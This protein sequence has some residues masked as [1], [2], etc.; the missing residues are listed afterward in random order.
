MTHETGGL[1]NFHM[2]DVLKVKGFEARLRQ[3]ILHWSVCILW[4]V[5]HL[6]VHTY[7]MYACSNGQV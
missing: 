7:Y 1:V 3:F 5:M 6:F 4:Q 2:L